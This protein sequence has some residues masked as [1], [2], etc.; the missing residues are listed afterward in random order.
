MFMTRRACSRV[1]RVCDAIVTRNEGL[2]EVSCIVC[3][4]FPC[5]SSRSL[6]TLQA[7]RDIARER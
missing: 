2:T 3:A 1:S 7:E 4:S 6:V 5:L